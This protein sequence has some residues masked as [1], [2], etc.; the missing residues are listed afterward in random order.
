MPQS[1]CRR[2]RSHRRQ[3]RGFGLLAAMRSAMSCADQRLR[4]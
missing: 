3:V 1:K 2:R 4:A